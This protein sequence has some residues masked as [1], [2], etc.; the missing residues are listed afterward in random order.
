MGKRA[1]FV[2]ILLALLTGCKESPETDIVVNKNEDKLE[3]KITEQAEDD[4]KQEVVDKKTDEFVVATGD[5]K[6]KVNAEVTPVD[7]K[8]S[9]VKTIPHEITPEDLKQWGDVLFAGEEVYDSSAPKSKKELEEELLQWKQWLAEAEEEGDED[10]IAGRKEAIANLE[11]AYE[12]ASEDEERKKTDYAFQPG[13]YYLDETST[14]NPDDDDLKGMHFHAETA[15]QDGRQKR[16][17]AINRNEDY[18]IYSLFFDNDHGEQKVH[19][20]KQSEEEA[21]VLAEEIREQ[22]NLKDWTKVETKELYEDGYEFIYTRCYEGIPVLTGYN[23]D[24][25]SDD[26]YAANMYYESL[27]IG[28]FNGEINHIALDSLMDIVEVENENVKT[29]SFDEV[30]EKFKSQMQ[31]QYSK[32]TY[33][34]NGWMDEND[35]YFQKE[36]SIEITDIEEGMFRI[37]V[38]DSTDEYRMV[39]AWIFKGCTFCGS[40][41]LTG[42]V[43]SYIVINAVDGSVINPTLG[44]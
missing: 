27:D 38:K 18:C 21:F 3:Q 10:V 16:L 13:E 40:S 9:V 29:L 24:L 19:G 14:V 34:E 4:K 1:L 25:R 30:Y 33:V 12:N 31:S 43:E 26:L 5:V 41:S 6:V 39:P 36:M 28:I 2:I 7:G 15:Y 32:N 37:K 22:L 20:K 11:T 8:V 23:I 44:Y 35:E 42:D 17:S